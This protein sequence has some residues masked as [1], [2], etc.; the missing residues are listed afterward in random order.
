[1]S[2]SPSLQ[3]KNTP[4]LLP[5][6]LRITVN[7]CFLNIPVK[8]PYVVITLGDQIHRTSISE[9]P[10]GYWN[11]GFELK[12]TYHNQLFDTIQLDLYDSNVFFLDKHIGR[13][14][15]RLRNLEGMPESFT[16]YY[17]VFEKRLA[18][19]AMSQV[20]RKTLM[21]SGVGAI[22]A[23][24]AY[25]YHRSPEELYHT[26]IDVNEM[27]Y[28]IDKQQK[29]LEYE[30]KF[31]DRELIEEFNRRLKTQRESNDEI[32]FNKYEQGQDSV[33]DGQDFPDD[34]G[35]EEEQQ[36]QQYQPERPLSLSRSRASTISNVAQE[37]EPATSNNGSFLNSITSLFGFSSNTEKTSTQTTNNRSTT[38]TTKTTTTTVSHYE[39][40]EKNILK[41]E[42]DGLKSFPLLNTIGS[43][44]MAK[45]TNQVLRA[46]AKLL[47]A[48]G[49]GF[50]LSNLQIL[51]GFTVVEKFYTDLPRDRTWDTV[52]DASEIEMASYMWRYA[53]AS[54]GWKGLNFIG[55]GNGIFSDAV[56]AQSDALS[57]CEHLNLNKEDLL[58]YELRTGAAFR[59]SYFIA[60]DRK[61]NAIVLS[62]RGT[63][64]TFDTMTDLV[65]EYE[66]WKGGLVHKGMKSSAAWFFRNVA[67]K[68]IAY[69]NKH[70]TTS[71]YI[72][73]HSLGAATGAILTI[74]LSDYLNEFRKGKDRDF[75][76]QCFGY[77]PACGLSLDLANRYK[78]RITSIVFADD[79]VSKLSYGSMMDV[80][81]L[82]LAGAEAAKNIGI[83]Q[84]FWASETN[85]EVWRDAFKRIS[86][87][88]KRCLESMSNPRL[89]VAGTVYQFWLDPIPNNESRI[90]IERTTP[91]KVSTELI[92]KKSIL[93]DH[94]P[95]NFDVAFTRA[96]D[97]LNV[98]PTD[99]LTMD[100]QQER[101]DMRQQKSAQDKLFGSIAEAGIK[102][103]TGRGGGEGNVV[104]QG[105]TR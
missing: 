84:L 81:E 68:L 54:Y 70:S 46:I 25:L 73:G 101:E 40:L 79:F 88:R 63:M 100:Q 69:V 44:A 23:Q 21:T 29:E 51:A 85:S 5:G 41:D 57:I 64:S 67:P 18:I 48:F 14:E 45:E 53:M 17:E 89:Y 71:L 19:G 49:Q 82:I 36:K 91:E 1:M 4:P 20:S 55:K 26:S 83:G 94:L 7:S 31:S 12:V 65:C 11:E 32:K 2:T 8:R 6:I 9:Y 22:Q 60:R 24:I 99:Q 105:E 102:G 28:L 43:W 27:N 66:P 35:T 80:K 30:N 87:C 39:D 42:D 38:T 97:S 75:N 86:E 16:S 56:R 47:V 37:I 93:L 95:T 52:Q 77:A 13:A 33:D 3:R 103:T 92:I 50:E 96:L 10:Q 61:L 72:V 59:P 62:I 58:A 34:S 76:I 98:K 74:M 78:D 104:G 90:V 15:I